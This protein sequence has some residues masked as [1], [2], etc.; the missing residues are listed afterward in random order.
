MT[1]RIH[2]ELSIPRDYALKRLDQAVAE[3]LPAYS[4]ARLQQWI[5]SGSL[6]ING[7]LA[8]PKDKVAGGE[9]VV[10]SVE[11]ENSVDQAEDIPLEVVFNDEHLI[12]INKPP[13]LVVHPGAGNPAGTLLNALLHFDPNLA[14][15]PRAGIVHRLDKDTSG[16]M[17][18]ARSLEAQNHLVQEIQARNVSRIY[19]ALVYGQVHPVQGTV[20]GAIGRHPVHRKKMAIRQD[21]KPA[22]THYRL[23]NQFEQHAHIECRL[24]SG[25]THQ[26]RVHMQSIGLPLIGDATYGGTYRRPRNAD[27][28]L[29]DALRSFSRQALHARGLGLTHPVSGETLTF[30][31]DAPAD[32]AELLELLRG[33]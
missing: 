30:Q 22:A 10:I 2:H 9:L 14:D 19:E 29:D 11:Q 21:G 24:E 8:R 31:V 5:K 13:D 12:V 25:R 28:W 20:E 4:R 32:F 23:L 15:I 18:V 16:L 33:E 1:L 3:L 26:I 7:E 6:T 27:V 17:V